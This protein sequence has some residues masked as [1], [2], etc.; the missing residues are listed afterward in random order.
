MSH[1]SFSLATLLSN[2]L[3]LVVIRST[4]SFVRIRSF[5]NNRKMEMIE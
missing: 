3:T 5:S 2:D 4:T 1:A